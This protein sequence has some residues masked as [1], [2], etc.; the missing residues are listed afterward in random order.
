M[1]AGGWA[2]RE[3]A[4]VRYERGGGG[5]AVSQ[6]APATPHLLNLSHQQLRKKVFSSEI[7]IFLFNVVNPDPVIW[8]SIRQIFNSDPNVYL[9][10]NFF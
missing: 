4:R 9:S 7:F 10:H 1:W 3:E 6:P 2:D 8:Q 5:G